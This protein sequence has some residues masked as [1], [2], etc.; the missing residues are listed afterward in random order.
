MQYK[1]LPFSVPFFMSSQ[2]FP[3][4]HP[5]LSAF[6]YMCSL[7]LQHLTHSCWPYSGNN[8]KLHWQ[9][10]YWGSWEISGTQMN[11][12]QYRK[13]KW[14]VQQYCHSLEKRAWQNP[15]RKATPDGPAQNTITWT[16]TWLMTC[17]AKVR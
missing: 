17:K 2:L 6:R 15:S 5:H 13:G 4:S 11:L 10:V 9:T 1:P 14:E 8:D 3:S 7:S 12:Y 16:E